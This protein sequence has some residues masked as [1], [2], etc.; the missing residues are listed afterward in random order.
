MKPTNLDYPSMLKEVR[1]QLALS[2]KHLSQKDL[3]RELGVSYATVNRR[4]NEQSEPSKLAR[5]QL[6]AFCQRMKETGILNLTE[7][8]CG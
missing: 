8:G 2:Q 3:D 4:E 5:S 7:A 1:R 6:D